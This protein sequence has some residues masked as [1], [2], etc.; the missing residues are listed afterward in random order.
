MASELL[1]DVE[2]KNGSTVFLTVD[3]HNQACLTIVP[4]ER[5]IDLHFFRVPSPFCQ[6]LFNFLG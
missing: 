1:E 4:N 3:R 6:C 5:Y 2:D